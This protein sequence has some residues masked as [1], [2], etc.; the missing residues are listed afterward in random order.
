MAEGYWVKNNKIIEVTDTTH[1]DFIL[2]HPEDFNITS[3]DEVE[4]TFKKYNEKIGVEGKAREEIIKRVATSGWIRVRH[5][6]KGQDYWSIQF[7]KFNLRKS[8]IKNFIEWAIFDS[9]VMSKNDTI[10][11]IG[12]NDNYFN[13][14]DFK[15]GSASAFLKENKNIKKI[16][17]ILLDWRNYR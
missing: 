10:V 16:K 6:V 13:I 5:Y 3:D 17:M 4:K 15:Q 12:Y 8:A 9:K 2:R 14:Y 11:L 1:I 7:D